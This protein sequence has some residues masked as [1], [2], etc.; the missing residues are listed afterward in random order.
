MYWSG[1]L[2]IQ[3]LLKLHKRENEFHDVFAHTEKIIKYEE[4]FRLQVDVLLGTGEFHSPA[5]ALMSQSQR[6]VNHPKKWGFARWRISSKGRATNEGTLGVCHT[7]LNRNRGRR[8]RWTLRGKDK[9]S[10]CISEWLR[11]WGSSRSRSVSRSGHDLTCWDFKRVV[12]GVLQEIL[13]AS[14]V[15]GSTNCNF[16]ASMRTLWRYLFSLSLTQKS[17]EA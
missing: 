9:V 1:S 3:D 8:D 16:M 2:H 17:Y 11:A 6:L 14:T 5:N 7:R 15:T 12:L 10:H 4:R 13:S